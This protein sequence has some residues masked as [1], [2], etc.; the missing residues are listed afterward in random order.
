MSSSAT[1]DEAAQEPGRAVRAGT[2]LTGSLLP[3]GPD[4]VRATLTLTDV[5][6]GSSIAE[7]VRH[8]ATARMDRLT[9]S[10][11]LAVVH[12]LAVR[13][14][15]LPVPRSGLRSSSLEA[16]KLFLSG[17]RHYRGAR[18]DSARFYY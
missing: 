15:D 3:A 17:E 5:R 16:V 1:I 18:W 4:S 11:T 7:V 14:S 12:E 13:H 6:S 10:L 8:E 2:V 9:D